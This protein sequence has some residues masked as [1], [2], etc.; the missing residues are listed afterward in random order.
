MGIALV[1]QA[2]ARHIVVTAPQ[3]HRA[4]AS[5]AERIREAQRRHNAGVALLDA[6]PPDH[7]GALAE[8]LNSYELLEGESQRYKALANIG[9]CY[10]GLWQYDR[11]I[12]YYR[13]YL[14][15]GGLAAVESPEVERRIRQLEETLGTLV[16]SV[17]VP[18]A[19]VWIDN[20][21]P[22]TAPGEIRIPGGEYSVEVRAPSYLTGRRRVQFASRERVT[23]RPFVLE[24]IRSPGF[25]PRVFWGML[26]GAGAVA[27]AG[28]I[29]AVVTL[30]QDRVD[31]VLQTPT[32]FTPE[33]IA[34]ARVPAITSLALF[35]SSALLALSAGVIGIW[36]T[37]WRGHPRGAASAPTRRVGF[38]A[39]P[40]G[41][42]LQIQGAF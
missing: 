3:V 8:F 6:V 16:I 18:Q 20:R 9:R 19:E 27:V 30:N 31:A 7:N 37:D 14:A 23:M 12:A 17:N 36:F 39:V 1:P 2:C 13:R 15:E 5:R 24:P 4:F 11:A 32:A 35:G 22:G 40:Q 21:N 26:V 29:T 34:S 25:H 42:G 33:E 28:G 10:E 41:V 38:L